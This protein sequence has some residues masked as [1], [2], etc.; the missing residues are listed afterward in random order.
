[1]RAL[2]FGADG[3]AGRALRASAP[4]NVLVVPMARGGCDLRDGEAIRSAVKGADCGLIINAAAFTAVDLAEADQETAQAVN[5]SAPGIMAE[6]AARIG[7]RFV[8]ISTDYVFDGQSASPYLP[9]SE[10]NP[11]NSY[12]A[13]KLAGERAVL[14]AAPDALVVRTSWVYASAGK[15]FVLTML[16]LMRERPSIR[17][18]G[19]QIG[20]PTWAGT[21]AKAIW[22]L[23]DA[24]ASGIMHAT[25][26]GV[27]SWYDFAA[28]IAEEAKVFALIDRIPEIVPIPSTEYPLPARRPA[29]SVLDKAATWS[30]LGGPAPHWRQ[31]LRQ[32]LKELRQH[33]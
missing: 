21:L 1:V 17:I 6:E 22:S 24:R 12:G 29:Y 18:V 28:G 15:N 10:P 19:D 11:I 16:R 23:A 31:S 2:V 20:T 26:A 13:S 25:D 33:G 9:S 7:A 32:M 8:Q 27:A 5:G 30:I 3:Q 4:R 14:E